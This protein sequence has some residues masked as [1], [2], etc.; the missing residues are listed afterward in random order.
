MAEAIMFAPIFDHFITSTTAASIDDYLNEYRR[1]GFVVSETT[2]RHAMGLRNGFIIFGPD[3]L[4][5]CWIEDNDL[6]ERDA[7][8]E[9]RQS[10]RRPRLNQIGIKSRDVVR[11]HEDWAQRGYE[12][13]EIETGVPRDAP[14]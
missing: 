3:Y 6:F 13:P 4:E 2:V 10:F 5:I 11:L 9:S 12:I 14:P 8:D 1:A 7:D